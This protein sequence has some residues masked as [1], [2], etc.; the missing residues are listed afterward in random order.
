M[1]PLARAQTLNQKI[2][3]KALIFKGNLRYSQ[4]TYSDL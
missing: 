2:G 1:I 3:V 4:K